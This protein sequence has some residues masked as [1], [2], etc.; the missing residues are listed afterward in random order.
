MCM[1]LSELHSS[2]FTL[3]NNVLYSE[4][5]QTLDR[6]LETYPMAQVEATLGPTNIDNDSFKLWWTVVYN[7]VHASEYTGI[8]VSM[9]I[10]YAVAD[11]G[12]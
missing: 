2:R 5:M 10:M 12:G 9:C 1:F 7:L 6:S 11:T 3:F 4:I 8:I